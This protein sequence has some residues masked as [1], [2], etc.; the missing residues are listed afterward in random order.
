MNINEEPRTFTTEE[1]NT[2]AKYVFIFQISYLILILFMWYTG[3][4]DEG[5]SYF[6]GFAKIIDKFKDILI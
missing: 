3:G 2:I 4:F 1:A 6:R 5:N